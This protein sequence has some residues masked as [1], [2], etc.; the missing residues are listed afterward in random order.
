ME[1]D[2]KLKNFIKT[3][4]REF[5]NESIS[6]KDIDVYRMSLYPDKGKK[7]GSD[8]MID[9]IGQKL[10]NNDATKISYT[11]RSDDGVDVEFSIGDI[12]YKAIFNHTGTCEKLEKY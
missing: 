10:K 7:R 8:E 5:L 1:K 11:R 9:K 3:T 4:I 6:K 2:T 12:K